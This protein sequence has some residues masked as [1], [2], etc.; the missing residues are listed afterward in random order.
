MKLFHRS[1]LAAA[2]LQK[3]ADQANGIRA[4][5]PQADGLQLSAWQEWLDVSSKTVGE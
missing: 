1:S 5:A 3:G 2:L 4:A